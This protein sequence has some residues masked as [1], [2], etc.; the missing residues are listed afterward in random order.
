MRNICNTNFR[1]HSNPL[2]KRLNVLRICDLHLLNKYKLIYKYHHGA[3]PYYFQSINL[4]S[5]SDEHKYPTRN[6][7]LLKLPLIKHE[8]S[9]RLL[10]Y[11]ISDLFNSAPSCII[12]KIVTHSQEGFCNYIK[13]HMLTMYPIVCSNKNCHICD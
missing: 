7:Y 12:E 13:Q 10:H 11:Q 1:S 5:H 6:R 3:L 4:L 9:K 2:F 8:F